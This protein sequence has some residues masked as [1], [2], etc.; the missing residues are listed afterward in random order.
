[1]PHPQRPGDVVIYARARLTRRA[2]AGASTRATRLALAT[3]SVGVCHAL[4]RR[5]DAR[6]TLGELPLATVRYL[7]VT[8]LV[9]AAAALPPV[10]AT[11]VTVTR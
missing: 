7:T 4:A 11:A 5:A 6:P 1:M 9:R 10:V 3:A 8:V 2:A